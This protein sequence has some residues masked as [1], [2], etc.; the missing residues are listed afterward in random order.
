[1]SFD[2]EELKKT[3]SDKYGVNTDYELSMK[4]CENVIDIGVFTTPVNHKNNADG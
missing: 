3:L 2:I 4:C 1:M